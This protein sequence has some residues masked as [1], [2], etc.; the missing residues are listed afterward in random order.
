M[1][2]ITTIEKSHHRARP[3]GG[4]EGPVT[5]HDVERVLNN[6]TDSFKNRLIL[7]INIINIA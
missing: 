4:K 3:G 6:F 5:G 7:V 1:K 2:G